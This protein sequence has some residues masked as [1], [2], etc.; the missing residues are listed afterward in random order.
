ML[1]IPDTDQ[2]AVTLKL[3]WRPQ[4]VQ[5]TRALGY[6]LRKAAIREWNKPSRKKF[7]SVNK[8]EKKKE[9]EI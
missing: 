2:E 4:D 1:S 3:P 5:D 6:L 9:L 7:L 8:D